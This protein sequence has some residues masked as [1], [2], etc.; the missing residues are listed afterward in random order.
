MSEE[1]LPALLSRFGLSDTE[2][3][4]YLSLL[5]HGEA[6]ASVIADDADVSK[7]YVYSVS[8][9][10]E[11]KGFVTVND[12]VVPTTIRARPPEEVVER[13]KNDVETM[14]PAL[15]ERYSAAEPV[16]DQFEVIKSQVTVLKRIRS[17][18]AE[19]D[20]EITLAIPAEH[21]D[22]VADDLREAVDRGVLVV[23]L[24]TDV[25]ELPDLDGVAS[26]TRVW[27]EM[28]PTM[29]TV[30]ME[31]GLVAPSEMVV[32]SN[33]E[34]QAIV[35]AQ[36]QL[37]PVIVGSFFGNYWTVTDEVATVDPAALP[38][39]FRNF[40][41]AVFEATL[42]L[43]AET[44][45]AARVEGWWIDS[46]DPVE[47]TGRVV[48]TVQGLLVPANN[49]FPIEHS[50]TFDVEGDT[51]TVGGQDAFLEDVEADTVTLEHA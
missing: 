11:E 46:G 3:D 24:V 37:A 6:K 27:G 26:V 7:R 1:G 17:L 31:F 50:L 38:V 48:E 41:R 25:D 45:I 40:R 30:D 2:V 49:E 34:R 44:D 29:L 51:V 22:A 4:T 18:I 9:T 16:V 47:L 12:H 23:L 35:F 20:S 10:L 28:M 14:G 32:R 15:E 21:F 43:R 42:H 19:A 36:S 39:T 8:E 5:E 33:S 13:L